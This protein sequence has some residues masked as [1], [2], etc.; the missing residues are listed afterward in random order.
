M[1]DTMIG[2]DSMFVSNSSVNE[3]LIAL[4]YHRVAGIECHG[5]TAGMQ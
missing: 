2:G 1:S 4:A 5:V 3:M